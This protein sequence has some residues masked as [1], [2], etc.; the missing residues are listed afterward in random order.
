MASISTEQNRKHVEHDERQEEHRRADT[1]LAVHEQEVQR[2]VVDGHKQARAAA[3]HDHVEEHELRVAQELAGEEPVARVRQDLQALRG[4]EGDGGEGADRDEGD[5]AAGVP[6]PEDAAEG[7]GDGEGDVENCREGD[8]QPVEGL[9]LCREGDVGLG[10][11]GW[12]EEEVYRASDGE[13]DEV[14]VEGLARSIKSVQTPFKGW[15][16]GFVSRRPTHLQVAALS[17]NAPPTIGPRMQPVPYTK[18]VMPT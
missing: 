18:P 12:E 9:D 15:K 8:A 5:G 11:E 16:S 14:E 4:R 13:D 17:A 10:G 7:K 2:D 3:G 1:R 6:G